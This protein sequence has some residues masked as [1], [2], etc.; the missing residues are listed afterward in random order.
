MKNYFKN[1]GWKIPFY[2][3]VSLVGNLILVFILLDFELWLSW[4]IRIFFTI[5]LIITFIVDYWS[6]W[7]KVNTSPI[8]QMEVKNKP[9]KGKALLQQLAREGK[10][11]EVPGKP[12]VYRFTDGFSLSPD[13]S[14]LCK[15]CKNDEGCDHVFLPKEGK[16]CDGYDPKSNQ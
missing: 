7:K 14:Y 15:L 12:G 3:I 5:G 2:A 11:E 9:L 16:I 10:M 6:N 4:I 8:I 1:V 13:Y